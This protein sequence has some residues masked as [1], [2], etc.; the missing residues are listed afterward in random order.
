MKQIFLKFLC[1]LLFAVP[2]QGGLS[3]Q[4]TEADSSSR[5]DMPAGDTR[6]QVELL[7]QLAE[8]RLT[9]SVDDSLAFSLDA[10][11]RA[12][13]AGYTDLQGEAMMQQGMAL[14]LMGQYEDALAVFR[15]CAD[16]QRKRNDERGLAFALNRIGYVLT[17]LAQYEESLTYYE[18]AIV[19]A[20]KTGDMKTVA[21]CLNEMG[22]SYWYLSRL[23][24][25]LPLF[26]ESSQIMESLG[27]RSNMAQ[28]GIN[29]GLLLQEIGKQAA[30]IRE[31]ER[32]LKVFEELGQREG[33]GTAYLN[34]CSAYS[35]LEETDRALDAGRKALE[36]LVE[37]GDRP[38][39]AEAN[40]GIGR[41]LHLKGLSDEGL[42]HL[43]RAVAEFHEL[44]NRGGE[45]D[46]RFRIGQLLVSVNRA[47]EAIPYLE[48]ALAFYQEVEDHG[49]IVR[50]SRELARACESTG[51]FRA[52][53]S[54][55][56]VQLHAEKER[57]ESL[58]RLKAE[59]ADELSRKEE[60]IR[61]MA[62]KRDRMLRYGLTGLLLAVMLALWVL[63]RSFMNK[64]KANELLGSLNRQLRDLSRTD[65][66]TGL[67]NRR[68]MVEALENERLRFRRSGA[69]FSVLLV[70]V[71]DFK[72]VNDTIGHDAG[73]LVLQSVARIFQENCRKTDMVCRW[74]GEEF[75]FLV[76]DTTVEGSRTLAEK[77]CVA[78]AEQEIA[79]EEQL[80]RVTVT[81]GVSCY[82]SAEDTIHSIVT[83]ADE[84][85][86]Q[87][88]KAGKNRAVLWQAI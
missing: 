57:D 4:V 61:E 77:V 69:T 58:D 46:A 74:G 26:R 21:S 8:Q 60:R 15:E 35:E 9:V 66:L 39:V 11:D 63:V 53:L 55:T 78:V 12:I 87:G 17:D 10:R 48:E 22:V 6:E 33:M 1:C 72:K 86:Y 18:K 59:F 73:D 62:V 52:A 16:L 19:L 79:V 3:A 64:K 45:A 40:A 68:S 32:C 30:A 70:D 20:R 65:A 83:R 80:L 24:Q 13:R 43:E 37:A 54:H 51:D 44:G 41:L 23:K 25:A 29:I 36:I 84:A 71:D 81:I 88:K 50:I 47:G 7:V 34:I 27:D 76:R 75:L 85:L 2:L 56:Q 67:P 82:G 42:E 31:Y 38:G 28:V 49:A 5:G 14:A